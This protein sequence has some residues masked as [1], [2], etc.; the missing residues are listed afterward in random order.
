[1]ESRK[2]ILA[3]FLDASSKKGNKATWLPVFLIGVLMGMILFHFFLNYAGVV[4]NGLNYFTAKINSRADKLESQSPDA[5]SDLQTFYGNKPVLLPVPKLESKLNQPLKIKPVVK[6]KL[7]GRPVAKTQLVKPVPAKVKTAAVVQGVKPKVCDTTIKDNIFHVCYFDGGEA[8]TEGSLMIKTKSSL[9]DQMDEF[10][11]PSPVASWYGFAHDWGEAGIAETGKRD[12]VT[13]I[14]RGRVNFM[15]GQYIFF[16]SSDDG[17][18]VEIEGLGKIISNWTDHQQ[19]DNVS[20]K[21]NLSAGPRLVTVRWYDRSGPATIIFG[22]TL[23]E[24]NPFFSYT[25]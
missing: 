15:P 9:L 13:A 18:E 2:E 8:M 25:Q 11:L 10:S 16:T 23:L 20:A 5:I 19:T 1:M 6:P 17:V 12:Q 7:I 14:W 21:L 22:W 3:E 4:F 24:L